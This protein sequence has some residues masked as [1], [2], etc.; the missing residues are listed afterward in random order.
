MTYLGVKDWHVEV[1]RGNIAGFAKV[2][3]FGHDEVLDT[4]HTV[5]SPG[6]STTLIDQSGIHRTGGTPA[7]VKVASTD[8]T[9]DNVGGDGALTVNVIGLDASGNLQIEAVTLGGQTEVTTNNTFSAVNA[10]RAASWGVDGEN[11]G[12][13]WCGTGT[14]T[15]GVPDTKYFAMEAGF[16]KGMTAIFTVPLGKTFYAESFVQNIATT[17][18]DVELFVDVSADGTVFITEAVFGMEPGEIQYFV[19]ALPGIPAN[20]VIRIEG[21]SSGAATDCTVIFNGV[22]IDD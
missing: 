1:R 20:S 11:G 14:F 17:N 4:T 22:L 13:I 3:I 15:A 7:V 12:A 21:E 5:I 2:A 19:N 8:D 18:K 16:N 10:L 6:A 9:N